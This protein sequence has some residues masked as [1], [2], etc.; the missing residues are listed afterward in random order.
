[1]ADQFPLAD[2]LSQVASELLKADAMAK[3]RGAAVMQFEHCEVEFA[4]SAEKGGDAGVKLWVV[5]AKGSA[6]SSQTN[7]IRVRFKSPDGGT[8]IQAPHLVEDAPAPKRQKR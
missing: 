8:A 1:M 2:V 3:A 7:R 6:K 5:N 4:V